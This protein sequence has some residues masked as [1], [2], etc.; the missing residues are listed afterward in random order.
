MPHTRSRSLSPAT[1]SS[2]SFS[3]S[4]SHEISP[5]KSQSFSSQ[6][7]SPTLKRLVLQHSPALSA[8]PAPSVKLEICV[9]SLDSARA[10][11]GG[12]AQRLEL[13]SGLTDGGVTPSYGLIQAVLSHVEI[14]VHV[15]I[16][17]RPGDFYYS[18]DDLAV[19]K[20]DIM[21]CKLSGVTG[22]VIGCLDQQGNVHKEHLDQLCK[23]ADGLS[24]T[25]HR[26]IDMTPEANLEQNIEILINAGVHRILSS[27]LA[28]NVDLGRDC[29]KRMVQLSAGRLRIMAGGGVSEENIASLLAHTGCH[30][31]HG[32]ARKQRDGL[33]QYRK[34]G[35]FMGSEK[36]N[37]GLEV[38]Y[39]LKVADEARV[40]QMASACEQSTQKR[41]GFSRPL[42]SPTSPV[43]SP[44]TSSAST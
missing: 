44:V 21:A 5:G 41:S 43:E 26:A 11:V 42:S 33:M 1:A 22:V 20:A 16:R 3:P 24:I 13:C 2:S 18:A 15:L 9:D 37:A 10:A 7:T 12:G 38:E 14:P 40:R 17:P 6:S 34:S 36:V 39:A 28:A 29:L 32:S 4:S 23:A 35:V 8:R 19:M 31:I 27:G 25:F 30:E